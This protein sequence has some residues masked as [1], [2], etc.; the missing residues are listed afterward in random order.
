MNGGAQ[1]RRDL[2]DRTREL[3]LRIIKLY[4]LPKKLEAQLVGKQILRCGTGVGRKLSRR[5]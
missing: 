3:A 1:I 4:A 2:R 5:S